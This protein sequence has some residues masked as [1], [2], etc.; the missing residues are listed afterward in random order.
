MYNTDNGILPV[1]AVTAVPLTEDQAGR[2]SAKLEKLIGKRIEL[3]NAV[4]PR[5][6]GG[7]RLDYDGKRVDDTVQHRLDVYHELTEV[8]KDFY[9]AR[10]KL[11]LIE[12]NQPI[13]DAFKEILKAIGENV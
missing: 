2:L 1:K 13:E 8:L 10:G 12:G 3:I 6:V 7:V 9:A 5:C 11:R 4:D